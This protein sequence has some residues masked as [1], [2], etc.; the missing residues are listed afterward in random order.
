MAR[1]TDT[2]VTNDG[3]TDQYEEYL[4]PIWKDLHVP[5]QRASGCTLEDFE[6]NEY[7]DLFSGIAVTNVGH[8][9][10]AVVEAA[11][12][13][14]DEFVHGCTYVH[15]QGPAAELAERLAEVTPGDL[16]KT[17]FCNSG[18]ESV[19]GAIKLARKYTGSKEVIALEMGF[20]GRTLGSLALTGNKAYKADMAPTINDVAHTPAPYRYRSPYRDADDETFV[21]QTTADLERV[22]GTHT[23]DDLAAIVVE[24]VMGEGGI[25]VPPTGYLQRLKEIA[26]DHGALLIAD[27]VQSGYGRTGELFASEHYD[28]VPDILTQAKG[29]ANGLPLG[30][31]T[32]PAE[33]ADAFDSGDHLSTF[34]GNPVACAAALATI[35]RLEDEITANAREQ[36]AWLSDEL[37]ALEADY[38]VVGEARGIG[39]MQGLE[40]VDPSG[41]TGPAGIAPEPDAEFAKHVGSHLREQGIVAGVGGYYKNVLRLQPPLSI[42]REQLER[43]VSGIRDAIDAELEASR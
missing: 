30:A 4:M 17:F 41:G 13:Q 1:Q 33:I 11:K 3:I 29:I 34:G 39:L 14:L 24:P 26:H 42:D 16:Q 21:E 40:F 35:D 32:A 7:L 15:P 38:D 37:A 10:D 5:V 19:E 8:G 27:E 28:A 36:G 31:F 22:I 20:H 6:G 9:D 12:D 23:A 2:T 43:G 25:I 18:T